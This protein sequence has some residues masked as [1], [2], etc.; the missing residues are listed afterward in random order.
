MEPLLAKLLAARGVRSHADAQAFLSPRDQSLHDP[1]LLPGVDQAVERIQK[2][3][4]NREII[5]I[6]GDYDVDG[7][8]SAA[9]LSAVFRALGARVN[10]LIPD[11]LREGYGLQVEHVRQASEEG[12]SLIVTCDCGSA[13]IEAV[14]SALDEGLDVVVTDHHQPGNPL[15]AGVV[16]VNPH[17]RLGS[18]PYQDLCGA[19][20]SLK[21]SMALAE[22][23]GR[24]VGL[25]SLLRVA[26][27]GTISDMVPLTGENRTIAA[28][29]LEA[30]PKSPSPGLQA[31]MRCAHLRPPL[32]SSDVAMRVGPRL[33]AAGRLA[34]AEL[35]LSLLLT[36]DR[37]QAEELAEELERLNRE[38]QAKEAA[39]VTE[40]RELVAREAV[41]PPIIVLW[42][43]DW[44]PGVVGIAAARLAQQ[45]H[46]PTLLF[47]VRDGV[48]RGSGRSVEG[49]DLF[50]FL[51]TWDEVL[52]RFGGHRSAV[53]LSVPENRLAS[54]R[55]AWLE[56]AS[57]WPVDTFER[58][59][60]YELQLA[61]ASEVDRGLLETISSLE[62]FGAANPQPLIRLGPLRLVREPRVFGRGHVEGVAESPGQSTS[63][64]RLIGWRWA[65]RRA[66]LEGVFEAIGYVELDR[67]HDEPCFR[68]VDVHPWQDR[69]PIADCGEVQV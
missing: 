5:T 14:T 8:S 60:T 23:C 12:A 65:T 13:A 31:L 38:R 19:G 50:A 15:P 48:A 56:A 42:G 10:V 4:R 18:Y 62:P 49:V 52:T 2:A 3:I 37:K 46:R 63:H 43:R 22:A 16:E 34:S 51:S 66:D 39:V 32:G 29:G 27:L 53:G 45:F 64:L 44:H 68:L 25:D 20:I 55:T 28:L 69:P 24:D 33:N 11:R 57:G 59:L 41:A 35:A 36:R 9:I 61:S 17:R 58:R 40:A 26:C 54:L 47:A 21:V 30:L 67:Y 1:L 7:V 6:V